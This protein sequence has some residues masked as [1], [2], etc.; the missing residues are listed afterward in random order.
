MMGVMISE[1]GG[2]SSMSMASLIELNSFRGEMFGEFSASLLLGFL[3]EEGC[4]L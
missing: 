4:I 2:L 1:D 3:T